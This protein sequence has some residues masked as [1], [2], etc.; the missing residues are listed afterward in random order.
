MCSFVAC[1]FLF[2]NV[3]L[4]FVTTFLLC[5]ICACRHPPVVFYWC[6]FNV[7]NTW[8]CECEWWVVSFHEQQ[9]IFLEFFSYVIFFSSTWITYFIHLD[10]IFFLEHKIFCPCGWKISPHCTWKKGKKWTQVLDILECGINK[11]N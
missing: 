8:G 2:C 11:R 5:S 7:A 9:G 4:L 3:F 1:R 10:K 6:S